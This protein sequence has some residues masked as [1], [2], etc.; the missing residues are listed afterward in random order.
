MEMVNTYST[1]CLFL[2][3]MNIDSFEFIH[4]L[5]AF[6]DAFIKVIKIAPYNTEQIQEIILKRHRSSRLKFRLSNV[7]EDKL[8]NLEMARLFSQIFDISKGNIGA[9]LQTWITSIDG[10][11]EDGEI[12]MKFLKNP[13]VDCLSDLDEDKTIII[14]QIL[15]HK[16][17]SIDRLKGIIRTDDKKVQ[18]EINILMRSGLIGESN[19]LLNINRYV[20]PHLREA[21]MED[22]IL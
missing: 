13:S 6:G 16:T 17:L 20:L 7:S 11:D 12:I 10:I 18:H 4:K 22:H 1:R 2:F 14:A 8:G 19:S 21:L 15:L 5:N 9:A 3:N